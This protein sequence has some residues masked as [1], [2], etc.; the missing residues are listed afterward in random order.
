MTDNADPYH[1]I[2]PFN[3]AEVPASI[4][5]LI[6]DQEFINA[7][8]NHRFEHSPRWLSSLL[9]PLV[10]V[11]LRLK[12]R[13]FKTVAHIQNEVGVFMQSL[14]QRTSQQGAVGYLLVPQESHRVD[15]HRCFFLG[16]GLLL[17][18]VLQKA[19]AAHVAGVGG[20]V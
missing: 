20:G 17:V 9:S 16:G 4:E 13:K 11:L 1:D 5:R 15:A 12:W 10:K 19:H 8:V 18:L 2:R 7:I 14:L 3:D 6:N